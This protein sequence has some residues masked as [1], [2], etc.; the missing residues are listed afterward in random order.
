M[1]LAYQSADSS[2]TTHVAR[3]A[4]TTALHDSKLEL[5]VMKREPQNVEKALC[6]N[7]VVN[8]TCIYV[9]ESLSLSS[10]ARTLEQIRR[11]RARPDQE[12][13]ARVPPC[14]TKRPYTTVVV[15][16]VVV[17]VTPD[18]LR[19]PPAWLRQPPAWLRQ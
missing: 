4:F 15:V 5:E 8:M 3:E 18:P 13:R 11:N 6:M 10:F 16:V 12:P 1:A 17:Y 2:L 14:P 7:C 19:Q 9:D